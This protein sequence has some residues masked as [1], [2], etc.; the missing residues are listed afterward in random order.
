M[1]LPTPMIS[2]SISIWSLRYPAQQHAGMSSD[3]QQDR[4]VGHGQQAAGGIF[5]I[6]CWWKCMKI[7][8]VPSHKWTKC[9]DTTLGD[10]SN[11]H[12]A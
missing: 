3:L 1:K 12:V 4:P 10:L 8:T 11:Y 5:H 2:D 7:S 9:V 6:P